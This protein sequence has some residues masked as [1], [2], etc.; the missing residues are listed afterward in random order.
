MLYR[1]FSHQY[2]TDCGEN[3]HK[4]IKLTISICNEEFYKICDTFYS[5]SLLRIKIERKF[6][7]DKIN[8]IRGINNAIKREIL[9]F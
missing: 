1:Y 8:K 5:K 2:T 3:I 6:E 7:L 4:G 9:L